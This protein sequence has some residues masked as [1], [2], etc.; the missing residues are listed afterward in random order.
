MSS[1]LSEKTAVIT[2]G[3][4]G[5]GFTIAEELTSQGV[6]VVICSRSKS[7]LKKALLVLNKKGSIAF[8]LVCDVSKPADCKKLVQFAKKKLKRIDVLVNNAGIYGPIG[9]FESINL[10][11]WHKA[12]NINLMGAV[13]CSNFAIPIMEKAGGG[14]IINL[15]GA[16]VGGS[17]TMPKFS[18]YFTSKFAIAGFSEVL[19]DELKEK[20]IQVNSISPG[21]VNTYLNEYLI[22]QGPKK[23]GQQIY[24]QAIKQKKEGGTPPQI[25]AKLVAFLASSES[26]R[27]SGR[28]LSAKW[29]PPEKLKEIKKYTQNLFKLRRIDQDLFYE[30]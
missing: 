24:D 20:N 19:A 12:L 5:I 14:K 21:A 29:N 11:N 10:K 26:D 27:I 8:G 22:K 13:Y 3:S 9:P 15:C 7:E 2:G 25:A 1:L 17:K 16:G 23:S 30:K 18:A 6:K 4:R 28:L